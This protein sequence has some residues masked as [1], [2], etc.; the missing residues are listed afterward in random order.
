MEALVSPTDDVSSGLI[1]VDITGYKA[2]GAEA[3]K[4]PKAVT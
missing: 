4:P 3:D 2:T 1:Y